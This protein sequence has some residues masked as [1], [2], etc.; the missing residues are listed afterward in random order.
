MSNPRIEFSNLI[1]FYIDKAYVDNL[2]ES[3]NV[4]SFSKL[5]NNKKF[6]QFC[7]GLEH[8]KTR[9][10]VIGRNLPFGNGRYITDPTIEVIDTSYKSSS[11]NYPLTLG[12]STNAEQ[13]K[14]DESVSSIYE[15]IMGLNCLG[16]DITMSVYEQQKSNI[17]SYYNMMYKKLEH[18][19]QHK[20]T[21]K[22]A[23]EV[24][25]MLN[26]FTFFYN[27]AVAYNLLRMNY[28][29]VKDTMLVE[30]LAS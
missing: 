21:D 1:E 15:N 27:T 7:T 8:V 10:V 2:T 23:G 6:K 11:V 17:E 14:H 29:L 13:H 4:F 5:I 22:D 30:G 19:Y 20:D 12:Y 26:S 24:V 18:E 3:I 25:D 16:I 28:Q 9:P